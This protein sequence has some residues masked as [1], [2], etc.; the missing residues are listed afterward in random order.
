MRSQQPPRPRATKLFA[1]LVVI[2]L[3]ASVIGTFAAIGHLHPQNGAGSRGVLAAPLHVSLAQTARLYC[4]AGAAFSSNSSRLA[5][6]GASAPCDAAHAASP[7]PLFVAHKLAIY[8]ARSGVFLRAIAL[9][10][11]I[12]VDSAIPS[13]TR[14]AAAVR[15]VAL[16]WVPN[17]PRFAVA[18]TAF[19]SADS[20]TPD[21]I[22]S[23]GLLL[24]NTDVG[25]A[26]VIPGDTGF[27]AAATGAYAGLPI[28]DV[29]HGV[30]S[31]PVA[32][33]AGLAYAWGT[34]GRPKPIISLGQTSLHQLPPNAGPRYPV[35]D[36]DGDSTFTIWQSGVVL[37]ASVAA[38]NAGQSRFVTAFPSW[39]PSGDYATLMVAGITL[40]PASGADA[41]QN[42]S[43]PSGQTA[44][45]FPMPAQM[46]QTPARDAALSAV[47]AQ[48]GANGW[49]IVSW[50][51]TGSYLA[52]INCLDS[53]G[54]ALTVR[55]TGHGAVVGTT[56]L[57][58]SKGDQGCAH[59]NGEDNLGDYPNPNLWLLWSPDGS[60]I[61]LTDQHDATLTFWSIA[62]PQQ[63][64]QQ[65]A[66]YA[67]CTGCPSSCAAA[68]ICGNVNQAV[69]TPKM[70]PVNTRSRLLLSRQP[71]N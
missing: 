11:F 44:P 46:A 71:K 69:A 25:T 29:A 47:Q 55:E 33:Q 40:A 22:V 67:S 49:A 4:P 18:F 23:F 16:G 17:S 43:G 41:A 2:A 62:Q 34:S 35:G 50:N 9:D 32:P 38:E 12:D 26:T 68:S 27:F 20:F 30:A 57:S 10:P 58:L 70:T 45:V 39:A 14:H 63:S 66:L 42:A 65:A 51:P 28:W 13:T 19:D 56:P 48:T 6:I 8:D 21:N 53:Q 24:V 52:S 54:E 64:Q 3:V 7:S 31:A 36:P 15:Y 59:F 5:L 60:H 61:L 37:G 1:P